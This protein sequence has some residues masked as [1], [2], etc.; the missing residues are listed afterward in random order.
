[1][2]IN[3]SELI[4]II[5]SP[6]L[7]HRS[8]S[9]KSCPPPK[10]LI[11]LLRSELSDRKRSSV[12]DHLSGCPTCV[13]E[14]KFINEI[15]TAEE[16]FDRAVA[17]ILEQR[18]QASRR[19]G[20][21][22]RF[23]FPKLSWSSVSLIAVLTTIILSTSTF[24]LLKTKRTALERGSIFQLED[25]SPN[26]ISLSLSDLIFR[27]KAIP[28]SEYYLVEIFDDALNLV[29]RS[30]RIFENNAI[31]SAELKKLLKKETKYLWMVTSY[32]KTGRR[33]ESDF[34]NFNLK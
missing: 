12:I 20:I 21:F 4:K 10:Q 13:Q 29:W 24:F 19:R 9:K 7:E 14:I 23:H 8:L 27:W 17:Q 2:K 25:I 32:L 15:L 11:A 5:G 26:N 31:P 16:N 33:I 30:E 34:A 28:D 1:M 18:L 3:Q 22:V 6:Y